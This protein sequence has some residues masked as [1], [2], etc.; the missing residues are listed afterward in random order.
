ML[1]LRAVLVEGGSTSERSHNARWSTTGG[2][3]LDGGHPVVA[4][5]RV[6][7]CSSPRALDEATHYEAWCT[8]PK[9][10]STITRMVQNLDLHRL[11]G[12]E[13]GFKR[14]PFAT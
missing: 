3:T 13:A 10:G 2:L 5:C 1:V 4:P 6:H 8:L 11:S 12:M 14:Y 9:P 7:R